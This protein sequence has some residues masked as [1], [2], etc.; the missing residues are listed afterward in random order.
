M[1]QQALSMQ[2]GGQQGTEWV[3]DFQLAL[4]EAVGTE[5]R[6]RYQVP[7]R[8]VIDAQS[9]TG[10][11][12]QSRL[13]SIGHEHFDVV[14]V[15]AEHPV[16]VLA[17]FIEPAHPEP[18]RQ[19]F[20]QQV[21]ELCQQAGLPML[22]QAWQAQYDVFDLRLVLRQLIRQ[23]RDLQA[24]PRSPR[25]GSKPSVESAHTLSD[26]AFHDG[27]SK[28]PQ[29]V[30]IGSSL[31]IYHR[32]GV[33][34]SLLLVMGAMVALAWHWQTPLGLTPAFQR[35]E[36]QARALHQEYWQNNNHH[37]A[38]AEIAQGSAQDK[39]TALSAADT[40]MNIS[41]DESMVQTVVIDEGSAE[42]AT[43]AAAMA[44]AA[45]ATSTQPTDRKLTSTSAGTAKQPSTEVKYTSSGKPISAAQQAVDRAIATGRNDD[46]YTSTTANNATP[47]RPSR[48]SSQTRELSNQPTQASADINRTAELSKTHHDGYGKPLRFNSGGDRQAE[49]LCEYWQ[50]QFGRDASRANIDA[51]KR[52]CTKAGYS[53][54]LQQGKLVVLKPA[55]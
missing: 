26:T 12:Q 41:T 52:F 28:V 15:K 46:L 53:V 19:G 37:V 4:I 25:P 18:A 33:G 17:L 45:T 47:S 50:G 38:A 30:G 22:R 24:M 11:W 1:E 3:E 23:R 27:Q 29:R 55:V 39:A 20:Y 43:T 51:V 8:E 16:V 7:I 32:I 40:Q 35:I 48:G 49:A 6:L 36:L 9:L 21:S 10:P 54:R 14:L 2:Y 5:Y 34:K 31:P 44:I 13:Q 42:L